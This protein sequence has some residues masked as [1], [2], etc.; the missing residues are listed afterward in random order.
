[1]C[2][3]VEKS[4][5]KKNK[6]RYKSRMNLPKVHTKSAKEVVLPFLYISSFYCKDMNE[7]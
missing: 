1:M 4:I 3:C 6:Y 7:R 5:H 2:T